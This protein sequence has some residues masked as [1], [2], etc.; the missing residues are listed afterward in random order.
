MCRVLRVA[1]CERVAVW[2]FL[3]VGVALG[4]S[5]IVCGLLCAI[6]AKCGSGSVREVRG[7]K[8]AAC[9]ICGVR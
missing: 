8:V 1:E 3:C 6:A 2:E 7:A 9:R 4:G 5:C